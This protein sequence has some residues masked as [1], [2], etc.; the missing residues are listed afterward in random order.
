VQAV[1][2]DFSFPASDGAGSIYAQS[3]T[4]ADASLVRGIFQIAHGMAEHSDRYAGFA[5]FLCTQG[6]AVFASDHAGHGKSAATPA[7]YG[8]FGKNGCAGVVD[9]CKALTELAKAEYPGKPVIFFGHSMGS[10]L[11]RK[12]VMQYADG[13]S[14]AVFCGTSAAN[15]AAGIGI[16]L[17]KLLA[18]QKGTDFRSAFLHKTAFG[19]YNKKIQNPRTPNDWLTRDNAIV[20]T[21]QADEACGFVFTAEAFREM[22]M[23]LQEV[24][25]PDAI[26]AL[27]KSLPLLLISG[28][29]DPVGGYGKGI[30]KLEGQIRAAGHPALTAILY[31]ND[32]HEILN[33]LDKETVYQNIADW[34]LRL[35]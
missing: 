22:F 27:P 26:A 16:A 29:D 12:Y 10:F 15:P 28:E 18:K 31:P 23:L 5:R 35:L 32:R 33:E 14:G 34:A 3:W 9:D 6:F 8:I 2:K 24:C 19:A 25:R 17:A 21:Y 13:L 4:P 1:H 20:D 7:Q 11:A 30:R